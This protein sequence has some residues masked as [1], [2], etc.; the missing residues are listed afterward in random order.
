[1]FSLLRK[2]GGSSPALKFVEV[3]RFKVIN[4]LGGEM[5][6]ETKNERIKKF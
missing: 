4:K 2:K 1:M 3:N 6:L 5:S